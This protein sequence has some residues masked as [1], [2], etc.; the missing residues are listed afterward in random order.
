T[1]YTNRKD[2]KVVEVDDRGDVLGQPVQERDALLAELGGWFRG[3]ASS[4]LP[5]LG[6]AVRNPRL[7][8]YLIAKTVDP[9]RWMDDPH[10]Y[11]HLMPEGAAWLVEDPE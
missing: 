6:S 10:R 8:A 11:E 4:T 2:A 7:G 9:E 5:L 1:H 3:D